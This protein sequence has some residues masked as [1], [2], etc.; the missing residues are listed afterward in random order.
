MGTHSLKNAAN[1]IGLTV[2]P[3]RDPLTFLL[4]LSDELQVWNRSRPDE[5]AA[6]GHFRGVELV[7]LEIEGPRLTARIEYDLFPLI[8]DARRTA[9][10]SA[11][12]TGLE[13]DQK[14][15]GRFLV[16][17]PFEVIIGSRIRDP[18]KE[19]PEIRLT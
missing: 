15:L 4:C 12:T 3:K 10:V 8:D 17:K 5:T 7:G 9:A 18:R 2:S 6:S 13:K 1:E 11:I 16:P 14:V 19:L